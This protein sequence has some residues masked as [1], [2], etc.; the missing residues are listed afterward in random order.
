MKTTYSKTTTKENAVTMV[1]EDKGYNNV[2]ISFKVT[3]DVW[4]WL[5]GNKNRNTHKTMDVFNLANGED[6]KW[7]A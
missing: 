5:N 7:F 4:A 6:S 2:K 3:G 1:V